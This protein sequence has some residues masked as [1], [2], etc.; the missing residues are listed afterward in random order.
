MF[1]C[2]IHEFDNPNFN[3]FKNEL[4]EYSYGERKKD[5]IGVKFSNRDGWQSNPSK[6]TDKNNLLHSFLVDSISNLKVIKSFINI[7][8]VYWININPK[9]ARNE[10]HTHPSCA[11]AGTIWIKTPENCGNLN[12]YSPFSH[13][14][15]D[16]LSS[17]E[18]NF[19]K[20]FNLNPTVSTIPKEGKMII[21]PSH[22]EH[23]VN[24]NLSNED[25]ISISFNL[26]IDNN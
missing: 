6:V 15:S 9:G 18:S 14:G 10:K 13:I 8:I 11:F 19:N 21:F 24:E 3:E 26:I 4:I 12:L 1:P 22:L 17:Y 5:P 7:R 20:S 25:R 16:E 2:M 23:S